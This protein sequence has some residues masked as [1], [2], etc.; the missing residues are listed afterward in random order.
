MKSLPNDKVYQRKGSAIAND[1]YYELLANKM[2]YIKTDEQEVGKMCEIIENFGK[3]C[4]DEASFET[5]IQLIRAG[6]VTSEQAS[7][8][9]GFPVEKLE[10]AL[11]AESSELKN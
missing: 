4:A 2:H 8:I 7:E 5:V 3:E 6:A 10:E 9:L 11:N 1:M